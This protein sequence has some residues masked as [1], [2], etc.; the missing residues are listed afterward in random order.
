MKNRR[1]EKEG[2]TF[3]GDT[4]DALP[5]SKSD[6][7]LAITFW[8]EVDAHHFHEHAPRS[9]LTLDL[10]AS[11]P[12]RRRVNESNAE[13]QLENQRAQMIIRA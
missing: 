7:S 8:R 2:G 4:A 10:K 12:D 3:S 5:C 9:S 6:Q 11:D 13:A 1:L